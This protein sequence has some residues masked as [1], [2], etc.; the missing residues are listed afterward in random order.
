LPPGEITKL[1]LTVNAPAAPGDY[2]LESDMLQEGVSWFG[3][4][5]SPTVRLPVEVR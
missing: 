5:G 3:L 4:T 1:T 2:L